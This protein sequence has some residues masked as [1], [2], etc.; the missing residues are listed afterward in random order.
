M[1]RGEVYVAP[2]G[3]PRGAAWSMLDVTDRDLLARAQARQIRARRAAFERTR[4]WMHNSRYTLS[5][6]V[7]SA[8]LLQLIGM[9][10]AE[11]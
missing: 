9:T 6:R 1:S 3:R 7:A 10:Q 4:S 2:D 5:H 8:E 11:F